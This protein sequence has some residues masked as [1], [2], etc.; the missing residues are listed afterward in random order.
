MRR[1]RVS[2]GLLERALH[3]A[4]DPLVGPGGRRIVEVDH[5]KRR[6]TSRHLTVYNPPRTGADRCW[7]AART[8]NPSW[9][10][11]KASGG[12]D[13][14]ALPPRAACSTA[15]DD[16][17]AKRIGRKRKWAASPRKPPATFRGSRVSQGC[18]PP[19]D[20]F[21]SVFPKSVRRSPCL[22]TAAHTENALRGNWRASAGPTT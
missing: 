19:P 14:H 4:D 9:G 3:G 10:P 5:R 21:P 12:F 22:S 6:G 2:P 17:T 8:S 16:G 18:R 7:C 13:S 20:C 1:G 11:T 15:G